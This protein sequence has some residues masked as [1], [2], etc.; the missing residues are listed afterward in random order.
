MNSQATLPPLSSAPERNSGPRPAPAGHE[1]VWR[2]QWIVLYRLA[3]AAVFVV[4][5]M[6]CFHRIA[7]YWQWGHNGFNGAAFS[8]AARNSIRFGIVG[9]A[10]YHTGLTPPIQKSTYTHHPQLL[11]FH[12]IGICELFG[13]REW[14]G[15]LVPALYSFLSLIILFSM[16]RRFWGRIPALA[17]IVIYVLT[18]INLIF[19]NMINHEQGG[20]FWC[21]ASFSCTSG[22]L[23]PTGPDTSFSLC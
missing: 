15:R 22:G 2:P 18:P 19:P 11:H 12:L 14:A 20:I 16:V 4:F 23:R 3:V 1:T 10:Q 17:A 8:Q 21:L 9:Q 6:V 7:N 13:S 5:F